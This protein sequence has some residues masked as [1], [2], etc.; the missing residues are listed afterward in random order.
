MVKIS[1]KTRYA[2]RALIR[3]STYGNEGTTLKQISFKENIPLKFLEQ[4]FSAL[5]KA[6]ILESKRGA[7]GGYR[8]KKDLSEITLY[9][10]M[11]AL[12]EDVKL[13]RCFDF[14]KKECPLAEYCS[15]ESFWKELQNKITK[16]FEETTL[17][18]K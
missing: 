4:I 5:V 11:K 6:G 18:R 9:E 8:L 7:E 16:I 15:V 17:G 12:R 10:V 13:A 3:L 2:V 14:V 1:Q